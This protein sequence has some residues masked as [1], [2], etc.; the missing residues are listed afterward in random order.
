[1]RIDKCIKLSLNQIISIYFCIPNKIFVVRC[2]LIRYIKTFVIPI[3]DIKCTFLYFA[4]LHALRQRCPQR[5]RCQMRTVH[6]IVMLASFVVAR[7][8]GRNER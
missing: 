4:S 6:F 1:M 8:G 2:I 5:S 3:R 7:S